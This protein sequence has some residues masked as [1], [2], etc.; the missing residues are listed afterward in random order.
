ME[1]QD[2]YF[3][4]IVADDYSNIYSVDKVSIA[5]EYTEDTMS[6]VLKRLFEDPNKKYR[7]S[8]SKE[9]K[10]YFEFIFDKASIELCFEKNHPKKHN[11][12]FVGTI[13]FN[14]NKLL[15]KN[16]ADALIHNLLS[17][18]ISYGYTNIDFAIDMPIDMKFV[19]VHKDNRKMQ[20]NNRSKSR[21]YESYGKI[22]RDN[23]F[24]LY[25]KK[26]ELY[27]CKRTD[28][29]IEHPLT[30]AETVIKNYHLSDAMNSIKNGKEPSNDIWLTLI[31]ERFEGVC[32]R[33]QSLTACSSVKLDE[34]DTAILEMLTELEALGST[35][36]AEQWLN[37]L[38][39]RKI[40]KL[41]PFLNIN[42]FTP[43]VGCIEQAIRNLVDYI[44]MI[45][46]DEFTLNNSEYAVTTFTGKRKVQ[47]HEW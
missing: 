15:Q 27:S 28:L 26:K 7:S 43:N 10:H 46:A 11:D 33:N 13:T 30:R 32:I 1:L 18:S 5:V 34:T 42:R 19:N 22:G 3:P 17:V 21:E 25:D 39:R 41:K 45:R 20:T 23:Y 47:C 37:K 2:L 31:K 29:N 40:A 12:L 6:K 9:Y 38:G 14:P 35:Q 16:G 44:E 8:K 4:Q 36:T 24:R